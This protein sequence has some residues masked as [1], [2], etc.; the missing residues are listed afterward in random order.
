MITFDGIAPPQQ[1]NGLN[2][3]PS[4]VKTDTF[5]IDGT[6]SRMQL[7][8]RGLA[9]L[10]FSMVKPETFQ[11]FKALY[12]AAQVVTYRNDESNVAGGVLEFTGILDFNEGD[13]VR[14]GS[15]MVPLEVTIMQGSITGA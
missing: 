9:A 15:L 2:E 5:A 12:D 13:F 11:F 1:P 8:S 7:P 4:K 3:N 6:P 14:G 10:T